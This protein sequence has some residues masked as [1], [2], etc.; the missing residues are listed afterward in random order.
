M[1]KP[2]G[3]ISRVSLSTEQGKALEVRV[4]LVI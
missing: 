1:Q 4:N 2:C 3:G